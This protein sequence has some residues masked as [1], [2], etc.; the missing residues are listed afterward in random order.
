MRLILSLLGGIVIGLLSGLFIGWVVAPTEYV[1]SPMTALAQRWR[2]EYTVMI[3][4]GYAVDRD[5][6]GALERL[7]RLGVPN[8]PQYVQEITERYITNSRNVAD[9][10]LLV[11]LAEGFGRLT[12]LMQDFRSLNPETS[13]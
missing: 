5:L 3:A 10:R 6:N 9:I 1:N 4:A 12:P 2:D 7:R 13:P 8:V 11:R